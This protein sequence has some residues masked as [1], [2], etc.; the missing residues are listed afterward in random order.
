MRARF[1]LFRLL[2]TLSARAAY[3]LGAPLFFGIFV[4]AFIVFGP[5]GMRAADVTRTM[6][7]SIPFS[8]LLWIGWLGLTTPVA[9]AAL[10][11]REATYL[12]WLPAPRVLFY[13]AALLVNL[14]VESPIMLLFGRGDGLLSAFWVG[15][16]A[17]AAHA[18]IISNGFTFRE[19]LAGLFCVGSAFSPSLSI[20]LPLA[21]VAA[22]LSVPSAI[23]RAPESSGARR[24]GFIARSPILALASTHL[25]ALF[26]L[27]PFALFRAFA[28]VFLGAVV[29]PL[30]A[31]GHDLVAPAPL[32]G[33]LLGIS[34]FALPPGLSGVAASVLRSERA[35]AWLCD[36]T[37]LPAASRAFAAALITCF[38][39]GFSG[40]ILGL[41]AAFLFEAP[42]F[43]VLRLV[44]LSTFYGV[45][46]GALLAAGAREASLSPKRG[47]RGMVYALLWSMAS[48][49][50]TSAW[51]ERALFL[52]MPIGLIFLR[53]SGRRAE[54]IRRKQG[55]S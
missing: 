6:R 33:L 14:L 37:G 29:F 38:G 34:S 54:T 45:A 51:G 44:A 46:T 23:R 43:L 11:P 30:A 55:F 32:G 13:L 12:R 7:S 27:D 31:R 41:F 19:G 24:L 53:A 35:A 21:L 48:A 39:G 49:A 50:A 1:A 18:I 16:L 36:T 15:I 47:D 22:L 2:L 20:A 52:L 42:L 26:R 40:L 4:V 17:S 28:L 10:V 3:V 5:T 25:L 9:R 8:T